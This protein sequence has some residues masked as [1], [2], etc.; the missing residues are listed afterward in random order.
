MDEYRANE[1]VE[2]L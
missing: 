1:A 2:L